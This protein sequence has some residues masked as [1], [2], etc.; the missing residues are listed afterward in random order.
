MPRGLL[1]DFRM[2]SQTG[3][4]RDERMPQSVEVGNLAVRVLWLAEI[5]LRPP[6]EFVSDLLDFGQPDGTSFVQVATEHLSRFLGP[7]TGPQRFDRRLDLR[8]GGWPPP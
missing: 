1:S 3:Q 8:R 6:L 5:A 2:N 4:H 7:R